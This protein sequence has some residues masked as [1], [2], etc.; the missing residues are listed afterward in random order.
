VGVPDGPE[1]AC[2][3]AMARVSAAAQEIREAI[4]SA[5]RLVGPQTWAGPPADRWSA[6]FA[7]RVSAIKR[8]LDELPAE[9]RRLIEKAQRDKA[10]LSGARSG[11]AAAPRS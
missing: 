1:V 11:D 2:R 9:Q 3:Q 8:L 7:A 5:V 4:D 10:E 6:E